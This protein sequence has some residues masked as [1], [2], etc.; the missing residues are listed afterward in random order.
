MG[1]IAP[2]WFRFT[3]RNRVLRPH[4]MNVNSKG[5]LYVGEVSTGRRV[6]KFTMQ[7]K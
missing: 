1:S 2:S 5:N 7:A 6:Q 3:R 4:G